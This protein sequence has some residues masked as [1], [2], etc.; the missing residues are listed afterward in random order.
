MQK[1]WKRNFLRARPWKSCAREWVWQKAGARESVCLTELINEEQIRK[2]DWKKF[3]NFMKNPNQSKL[4][5]NRFRSFNVLRFS[6]E[7]RKIW[8]VKVFN[9]MEFKSIQTNVQYAKIWIYGRIVMEFSLVNCWTKEMLP[10]S[11]LQ[12]SRSCSFGSSSS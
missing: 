12:H 1:E 4:L 9:V 3:V 8:Q 5:K 2:D 11:L 6:K 10:Q 7:Q